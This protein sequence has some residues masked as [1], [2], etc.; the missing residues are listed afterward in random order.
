MSTIICATRGGEGSLVAQ[1]KAITHAQQSGQKLIFVYIVDTASV[2]EFDKRLEEAVHKEMYWLGT[3][4]LNIAQQRA[5]L[6]DVM[7]ETTVLTGQLEEKLVKCLIEKKA[8]LL[9]LGA[10]RGTTSTLFGD[11]A[12]EQ[13]VQRLQDKTGVTV[14][15]ARP[16]HLLTLQ[17][18][19]T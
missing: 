11:D 18:E 13:L 5:R 17:S 15:I 19:T 1:Q 2:G 7:A 16:E 3:V 12:I 10:P 14:E 8:D 9:L 6:A 4:L